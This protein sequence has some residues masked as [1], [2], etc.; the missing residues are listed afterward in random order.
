MSLR[1]AVTE[2]EGAFEVL[3]STRVHAQMPMEANDIFPA[4]TA[5]SIDDASSMEP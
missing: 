2:T 1:I 3:K 5:Y 4:I